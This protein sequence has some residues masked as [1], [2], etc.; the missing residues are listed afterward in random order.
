[1][2][3]LQMREVSGDE[4]IRLNSMNQLLSID[5]KCPDGS[6]ETIYLAGD[7]ANIQSTM[8]LVSSKQGGRQLLGTVA[9]VSRKFTK[10]EGLDGYLEEGF[11]QRRIADRSLD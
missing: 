7:P 2:V 3:S 4:I 1:M 9:E 8:V 5:W 10:Y 6:V 11:I